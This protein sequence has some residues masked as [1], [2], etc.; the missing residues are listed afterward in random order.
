MKIQP[1][2]FLLTPPRRSRSKSWSNEKDMKIMS[3]APV[4]PDVL[5]KNLRVIFCGTAAGK[6][7]AERKAYYAHPTNRFWLTLFETELTP[8]LLKP[9][10][11]Q[12][13]LL[14]K[15]GLTD[16]CK[17]ESGCDN[18]LSRNALKNNHI[19]QIIKQYTPKIIA[20]TSKKAAVEY[21]H[22]DVKYG[23]ISPNEGSTTLFVLP[24]PSAAARRYWDVS[25]WHQ[26]AMLVRGE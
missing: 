4:L 1:V 11:F 3:P 2:P 24:S 23:C 22:D 21:L 8:R 7:S 20:F 25:Y 6:R 15:I 14:F 12:E 17:S 13:V 9:E 26:L 5:E 16:L 18:S 10:D 19:K